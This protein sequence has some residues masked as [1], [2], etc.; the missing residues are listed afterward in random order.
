MSE[1]KLKVFRLKNDIKERE[2][3]GHLCSL[4]DPPLLENEN[5]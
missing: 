1:T 4:F 5:D 2:R 3:E